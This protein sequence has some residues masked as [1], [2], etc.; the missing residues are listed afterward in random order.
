[1]IH[2]L[3]R[4]TF[5][6]TFKNVVVF[7]GYG[8][9]LS[10]K[11]E[12]QRRRTSRNSSTDSNTTVFVSRA[13]FL[14][15][16]KNKS[17]LISLLTNTFLAK[18]LEIKQAPADADTMI[19]DI[20]LEKVNNGQKVTVVIT[21]TDIIIMLLNRAGNNTN[22][23]VVI[24]VGYENKICNIKEIQDQIGFKKDYLMF[25]HAITG[26]DTTSSFLSIIFSKLSFKVYGVFRNKFKDDEMNPIAPPNPA[27]VTDED[28][29][30]EETF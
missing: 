28:F 24:S 29:G 12:E 30:D 21:D 17:R 7:D 11:A 3:C 26:C 14:V 20:T 25:V 13:D 9:V 18:E 19:V 16:E 23:Q 27:T 6:Y 8:R 1:M 5:L 22:I 15:T 10:T 4:T 2:E